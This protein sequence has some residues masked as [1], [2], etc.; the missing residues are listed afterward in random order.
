MILRLPLHHLPYLSYLQLSYSSWVRADEFLFR[1]NRE[2]DKSTSV[3]RS[4]N[5][6]IHR[7]IIFM[8]SDGMHACMLLR[9]GTRSRVT[10]GDAMEPCR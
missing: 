8:I 2:T 4:Q 10:V 6:Y 7:Y 5:P 1:R 3:L 9:L